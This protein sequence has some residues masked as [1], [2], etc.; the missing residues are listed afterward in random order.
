MHYRTFTVNTIPGKR[1]GAIE[2]LKK[3]ATLYR[4]KYRVPTEVLSNGTGA[5][6]RSHVASKYQSMS[7][8]EEVEEEF[9]TS[10]D[11]QAW[12]AGSVGL[13]AWQDATTNIY[14]VHE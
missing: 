8:M 9:L 14:V 6:Y 4:D 13:L 2:H 1:L 11:F 10:P 7:R 3:L 5:V 12:F